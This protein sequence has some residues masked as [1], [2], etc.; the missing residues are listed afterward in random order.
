MK[1]SELVALTGARIEGEF[2][3]WNYGAAG[4]DEAAA[5]R[6]TFLANL[7]IRHA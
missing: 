4:L 7:V 3:D 5:D 1:L 6:S 2:A